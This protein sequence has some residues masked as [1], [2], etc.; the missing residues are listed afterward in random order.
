MRFSKIVVFFFYGFAIQILS[1]QQLDSIAVDRQV[2]EVSP[3]LTYSY[4][5]PKMW[6][7]I[8]RSMG[9]DQ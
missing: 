5:A 2:Y 9:L 3:G 4:K 1:A 7:K 6:D 8:R